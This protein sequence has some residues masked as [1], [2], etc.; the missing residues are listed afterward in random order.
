MDRK[1]ILQFL[2]ELSGIGTDGVSLDADI[3]QDLGI[4]SMK[5]M[6]ILA[7]VEARYAIEFDEAKMLNVRTLRDFLE[8][9]EDT[10]EFQR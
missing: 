9:L 2:S 6:R 1:E 5:I 8:L 4:T 7:S 3:Q 10:I